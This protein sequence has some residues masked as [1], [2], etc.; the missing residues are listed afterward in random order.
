MQNFIKNSLNVCFLLLT[1]L[2]TIQA[3]ED[4][5]ELIFQKG[6]NKPIRAIAQS[7]DGKTIATIGSGLMVRFRDLETGIEFQTFRSERWLIANEDADIEQLEFSPDGKYLLCR[8]SSDPFEH[9]VT[10]RLSDNKMI[11]ENFEKN[12]CKEVRGAYFTPDG[13]YVVYCYTRMG[14]TGSIRFYDLTTG[15]ISVKKYYEGNDTFA[16]EHAVSYGLGNY[17]TLDQKYLLTMGL[18]RDYELVFISEPNTA[19]YL[20][21]IELELLGGSTDYEYGVFPDQDNQHFYMLPRKGSVRDAF[22]WRK[23]SIATGKLVESSKIDKDSRTMVVNKMDMRNDGLLIFNSKDSIHLI[24]PGQQKLTKSLYAKTLK[25]NTSI[26]N[27][28]QLGE[29]TA[30]KASVDGKSIF[31]AF[32]GSNRWRSNSL[33]DGFPTDI[34]SI[35]QLDIETG[36]VLREYHSLGKE[37]NKVEFDAKGRSLWIIENTSSYA[38]TYP[39]LLNIWKFRDVGNLYN[40]ELFRGAIEGLAHSPNQKESMFYAD[41]NDAAWINNKDLNCIRKVNRDTKADND[42]Q[43]LFALDEYKRNYDYARIKVNPS[44]T[45]VVDK[46][47]NV[48]NIKEQTFSNN[49]YHGKLDVPEFKYERSPVMS[50]FANKGKLFAIMEQGK[51]DDGN[52]VFIS[53]RIHFYD[54]E[55]LDKVKELKIA[56]YFVR[57]NFAFNTNKDGTLAAIATKEE[58]SVSKEKRVEFTSSLYI[59]DL[60][61]LEIQKQVKLESEVC[62]DDTW[63]DVGQRKQ[64]YGKTCAKPLVSSLTFSPDDK[65]LY[66]GWLDN[67]I[68]VWD[69]VTGEVVRTLK[70]HE[71][72]VN[73]I[74]FHPKK[75]MMASASQDGQILFWNTDTWTVLATMIV[76]E[77]DDYIIYTKEGYYMATPKALDWVV[78]KKG[79]ELY[80]FEQFDVKYNR[81][82]IVM[83][84]LGL[85]GSSMIKILKKAYDKR[86]KRLGLSESNL[87]KLSAPT[88]TLK[89]K[90]PYEADE[91]NLEFKVSIEDQQEKLQKLNVYVNDVPIYGLHGLSLEG[92]VSSK[93]DKTIKLQLS[94]GINN[95][96]VSATNVQGVESIRKHILVEYNQKGYAQSDLHLIVVG[97]S[98]YQD[99]SRNLTFAAKDA[100]DIKDVFLTQRKHYVNAHTTVLTNE[101]AT[102][103]NVLKALRELKTTNVDDDVILYFSCHGLLDDKLDYY[104]AMHQTDF[105][106][107]QNGGL[108]YSDIEKIIAEAPARKK[109]IFIDACHSGEVDKTEVELEKIDTEEVV[110]KDVAMRSKSGDYVV[111]PKIGLKNS[112]AYMQTLFTDISKGTGATVISAAGGMEFALESNDWQNSVFAYA[113]LQ[114]VDR[115]NADTDKNKM[116][117]IS[118]LQRYVKYSVHKMTNGKQVPT[119]RQVNRFGDFYIFKR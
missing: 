9:A 108:S 116:I 40:Q 50:F 28:K 114:A 3:Q 59:L 107:P 118:E 79:D 6:H 90:V 15:E 110:D 104:L 58:L 82:D 65:H 4:S 92:E 93:F 16:K 7:P 80:R 61:N 85:V 26:E 38:P 29:L 44:Y 8:I 49:N 31:V 64:V 117:N 72:L 87:E 27:P 113:I 73:S 19:K 53:Q 69:V 32:A 47:Y 97:V 1:F 14:E 86:L 115:G 33:N 52:N 30:L 106:Q 55:S 67:D 105:E 36:R 57:K 41:F 56:A 112:F 37:V 78:F 77:R 5:I 34:V 18:N 12:R 20:R 43:Q 109:L 24:R 101:E 84:S 2:C 70:G 22:C 99:A 91:S 48:F 10:I 25:G 95:I 119:T 51:P 98:N 111:K 63:Y 88:L 68:R 94:R 45:K 13:K 62:F 46:K 100:E 71:S 66:A 81:P 89:N 76:I 96:V 102:T 60:E 17:F 83:D 35:R 103:E 74:S 11:F 21:R 75:P 42:Q 23:Y 54:L 39:S